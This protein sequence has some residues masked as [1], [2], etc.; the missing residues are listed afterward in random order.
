MDSVAKIK[1]SLLGEKYKVEIRF[2]SELE[3]GKFSKEEDVV[4]VNEESDSITGAV[5][6]VLG[7]NVVTE[8]SG[9]KVEWFG[10]VGESTK[11]FKSTFKK[12]NFYVR[13]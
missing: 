13:D 8:H 11:I 3:S 1:R 10:Q 2:D 7:N 5:I 4:N 6:L 9:V 12:A